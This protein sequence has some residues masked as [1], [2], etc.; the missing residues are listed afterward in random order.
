MSCL[1][2]LLFVVGV[3]F[4][5][6]TVSAT[7]DRALVRSLITGAVGAFLLTQGTVVWIGARKNVRAGHVWKWIL[8]L[9][10]TCLII[11]LMLPAFLCY[12]MDASRSLCVN[13]MR[14]IDHAK[15]VLAIKNKWTC[16]CRQSG[17]DLERARPI[18]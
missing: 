3:I 4:L 2:A 10:V 5:L 16:D 14:L 8:A 12:R 13:N 6:A 7:L 17:S 1:V 15:E 18:Y 9:V 11:A